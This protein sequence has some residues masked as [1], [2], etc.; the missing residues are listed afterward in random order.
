MALS[1]SAHAA[2]AGPATSPRCFPD[3]SAASPV[4]QSE[5]LTTAR[6]LHAQVR[7]HRLGDLMRITL[8]IDHDR[9]VYRLLVREPSGHIASLLVDARKPF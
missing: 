4:V 2:G 9:Y 1:I 5:L 8:C 7:T 3:W 6:D